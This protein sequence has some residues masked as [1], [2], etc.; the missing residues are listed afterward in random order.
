MKGLVSHIKSAF[1]K[2]RLIVRILNFIS[3]FILVLLA[4]VFA[5]GQGSATTVIVEKVKMAQ[6]EDTTPLIARLVATVDSGIAA[7]RNGV[8]DSVLFQIGDTIK[9]GQE[10]VRMDDQLVRIQLQN[11]EATL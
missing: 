10:L 8:V 3:V 9:K 5:F 7:R 2:R 6:I 11:A 1:G 4:P